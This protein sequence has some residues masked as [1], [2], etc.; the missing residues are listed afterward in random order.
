MSEVYKIRLVKGD[1]VIVLSGKDKGKTGKVIATHPTTNKVTV[2]GVNIAKKHLKPNKL[3]PQG[4]IVEITQ[5]I[6]VSKV[7]IIEPS[8]K[9][10]SRIGYVINSD[11]KKSRVYK[12]TNKEIK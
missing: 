10:V 5:P 8:S 9:K 3:H 2:E 12:K 7:A 4:G 1:N 11:G 6:Y